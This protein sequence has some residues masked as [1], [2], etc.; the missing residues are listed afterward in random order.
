MTKKSMAF[1]SH[2]HEKCVKQTLPFV[3]A[4][5]ERKG[6]RLTPLRRRVLEILLESHKALGAYEILD[7]LRED[8]RA[9]Q[10]PV[11]YRA[12]DFLVEQGF[13]HK[14]EGLS[15]FVA[16]AQQQDHHDA[17]LL[18]CRSCKT[19]AEVPAPVGKQGL[20]QIAESLG[21]VIEASRIEVEG[22]C[23]SCGTTQ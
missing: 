7:R 19:V 18:V 13:V 17:A 6:L 9:A 21:F 23:P 12:L 10:P 1:R 20:D 4:E 8:G 14:I 16:C 3:E 2:D 11:A 5:C 15:A 22:L